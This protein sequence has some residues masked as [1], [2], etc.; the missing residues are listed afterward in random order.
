MTRVIVYRNLKRARAKLPDAWSVA[1]L[2]GTR[3]RGRLIGHVA[4]V[5][6]R[7]VE[8]I[9]QESSRQIVL[10]KRQRSVHAFAIEIGRAHV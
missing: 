1:E 9:V 8:F 2:K 7:D 4:R 6:L 5:V 3:G 10:A